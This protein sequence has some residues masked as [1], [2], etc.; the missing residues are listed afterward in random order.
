[1]LKWIAFGLLFAVA[2][3]L[4]YLRNVPDDPA[5]WH[6]DPGKVERSGKPNDYLLIGQD[7]VFVPLSPQE[8]IIA[9][10]SIAQSDP[11]T[12]MIAGRFEDA[13][14]TY[15]QRSAIFRFPDY[16]SVRARE[17]EGGSHLSIY[18]R[19]RFGYSDLGANK[20]RIER[21]L[22]VLESETKK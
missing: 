6:V 5:R 21:W 10:D 17:T 20:A 14:A 2:I 19:S 13:H 4:L 22:D 3:A 7:A 9:F 11:H 15:V 18:S 16:I 1:M 8:T 12:G